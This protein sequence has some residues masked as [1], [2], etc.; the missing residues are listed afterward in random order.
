M[1]TGLGKAE[2]RV[3]VESNDL[4]NAVLVSERCPWDEV[5]FVIDSL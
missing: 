2:A 5:D 4:P 3:R 1:Q